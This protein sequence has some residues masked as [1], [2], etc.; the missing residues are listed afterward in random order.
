MGDKNRRRNR[1]KL[2]GKHREMKE[3]GKVREKEGSWAWK[4][5]KEFREVEGGCPGCSGCKNREGKAR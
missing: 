1:S 4:P 5:E 3:L 2:R